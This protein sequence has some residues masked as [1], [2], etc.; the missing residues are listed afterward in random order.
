MTGDAL[1]D[2]Q[3]IAPG[4]EDL[5]GGLLGARSREAVSYPADGHAGCLA[6]EDDSWWFAHRNQVLV[7]LMERLPPAGF[8]LDVGGGNGCVA[9]A[10]VD[11]GHVVALLEPGIDGIRAA[12]R[13]GLRNLLCASLDD[14]RFRPNSVPAAGLFDVVEHVEGDEA[15]LR[16]LLDVLTPG[17]RVYL[18]VPAHA[19]LWSHADTSAGHFRRYTRG[20]LVRVLERSG[21]ELEFA[22]YFFGFLVA[23]ILFGRALPDR[24]RAPPVDRQSESVREHRP[25]PL[26][27]SA[28]SALSAAELRWLRQAPLPMGASVF[29]VARKPR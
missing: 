5:G 4:L 18:T 15:F 22:S 7:E 25:N 26:A 2:W 12:Q 27:R 11:A 28:V 1:I 6:V 14:A 3:S 23:P 21:F 10:L 19:W 29:A 9:K 17:G 13:R 8:L 24:F 16:G 20:S